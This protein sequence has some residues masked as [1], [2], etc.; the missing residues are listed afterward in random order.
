MSKLKLQF[1]GGAQ[2]EFATLGSRTAQESF[3]I[4]IEMLMDN[5]RPLSSTKAL[6]GLGK[7]VVELRRNGRP[8]YRCVYVVREGTIYVLHV[9]SKTSDGTQKAREETIKKR[10]KAI[11]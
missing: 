10:F 9:F 8:A 4:D 6:N 3:S 7:G 1:V 2:K 11:P 5:L